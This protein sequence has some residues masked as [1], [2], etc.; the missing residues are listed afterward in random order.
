M[1]VG[2]TRRLFL[3]FTTTG[4][5]VFAAD[6]CG[7]DALV[8]SAKKPNLR[9]GVTSDIHIRYRKAMKKWEQA[10][11]FFDAQK[12]DG[13]LV[14]GDMAD[15]GLV[16]ELELVAESWFK[17]FPNGRR[18]DGEPVANLLHY[19][20]HD[21]G[22]YLW[23]KDEFRK[24]N[25]YVR[26]SDAE[27]DKFLDEQMLYRFNHRA[28][29]WER[30]FKEKFE[31][32]R[33]VNVKGYDFVLAHFDPRGP[34]GGNN[35]PGLREF[36]AAQKFDPKKPFFYSQ[37]RVSNG[38]AFGTGTGRKGHDDGESTEI[39]SHYPNCVAFCG[40]MHRSYFCEKCFWKGGF[41]CI[42]IP[43]LQNPIVASGSDPTDLSN[44]KVDRSV[45]QCYV[46]NVY[47]DEIVIE[48]RNFVSGE[49]EA[50]DWETPVRSFAG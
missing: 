47:D 12:V 22:G 9:I 5:A 6:L 42:Q 39:L 21:T 36:L 50:E 35:T 20:D 45:T 32:I 3:G 11:H 7:A 17:V 26:M 33:K 10:L 15:S 19:G 37:H 31:P 14:S 41:T 24:R 1:S 40:H 18:S 30:C 44:G 28:E 25:E 27:F 29:A 43:A 23:K 49:K 34:K 4:L 16:K 48:R 13:V 46:L 8:P 2:M 38:T